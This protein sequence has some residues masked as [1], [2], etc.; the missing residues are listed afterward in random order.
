[1]IEVELSDGTVLEFPEGTSQDVIDRVARAETQQR[2]QQSENI[3]ARTPDGGRVV[4]RNGTRTFVSPSFSS[5]DPATID[6]ILEGEGVE[7]VV[8][9]QFDQDV[10]GR[11]PVAA[12]ANEVVRGTPFIG[13][14][15]DEAVGLVSP[16]ARDAM[17]LTSDAMQREKPGQT[18]A[19]NLGGAVAGSVPL[20]MAAAPSVMAAAPNSTAARMLG[21]G[22]LGILGGGT[23]GAV[24][25]YGEGE[26]D[27]RADEAA[28]QGQF[29]A[30]AGG[31]L[32]LALPA[33]GGVVEQII[34]RFKGEDVAA[35]AQEFG[36]SRDAARVLKTAFDQ[37]DTQAVDR[38]LRAGNEA[39]L[40][41]AGR[42]GQALLDAAAQTGGRPLNIVDSAVTARANRSNAVVTDALDEALGPVTGP[43]AAAREVAEASRPARTQAYE[44]AYGTPIDY[45]GQPGRAVEDV[46]NRIPPDLL[47]RA[48]GEANDEMLSQGL[49]NQQIMAQ[50][51]DD[52][53][54]TFREMPN[55]RQLDALKQALDNLAERD[56]FGRLTRAG[57]RPARLAREV[58]DATVAA[59][60]GQD[61]TYAKALQ[62]GRDKIEMDEGLRFGLRMLRNTDQT[63]REMVSEVVSDMSADGRAMMKRGLRSYIDEVMAKT[64]AIASDADGQEA[65]EAISALRE[66]GSTTAQDKLRVLLGP[67]EFA[68]L[69]PRLDEA[70]SS[71]A[72]RAAV[73]RNSATAVRQS[74]QGT[75]DDI[76]APGVMGRAARGQP[77]DATGALVQELMATTPGDDAL[78]REGIWSDV[79]RVL[80][81]QRG[82]RSAE[83]ALRF[84]E[85]AISGNEL[86]EAQVRLIANQY[87]VGAGAA[88]ARTGSQV[89]AI[90]QNAR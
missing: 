33:A 6:R 24:Y 4:M 76:T 52:G 87:L 47:R 38:I 80:T 22:L 15:A 81:E 27:S 29:G 9:S 10:I 57:Q 72:M 16:Q 8:Q 71:Q 36:V 31:A 40:A 19:L 7:R 70:M 77:L 30:V 64:R 78:R 68:K 11:N 20:A 59:T 23:E 65:R 35:I 39:M 28:R 60:G 86:S 1:M 32:G 18:A 63:T 41:D 34:R 58:R 17:R 85:D 74:V 13:S 5:N 14:Y 83:T 69:K 67:E 82:N 12:R 79:A 88:S 53:S 44:A 21:G 73:A 89:Q 90:S 66:L 25:G 61:G 46:F 48:V 54:V 26:G 3:I 50:I 37:N 62:V 55:V 49:R 75:V 84:I 43:R 2:R 51:A 42:S 56:E 45:S